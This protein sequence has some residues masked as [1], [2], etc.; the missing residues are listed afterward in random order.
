M[1][2]SCIEWDRLPIALAA[3]FFLHF[4]RIGVDVTRLGEV[5][6]EVLLGRSTTVG[7]SDMITVV[8]LVG[9]SH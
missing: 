9:A 2:S 3:P 4:L 6:R 5:A 8:K 1:L 7:E